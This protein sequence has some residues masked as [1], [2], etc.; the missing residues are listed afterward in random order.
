MLP[1]LPHCLAVPNQISDTF[2]FDAYLV[3]K[4]LIMGG[5]IVMKLRTRVLSSRL[6]LYLKNGFLSR[7]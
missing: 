3:E 4:N 1:L 7:S 5:M 2:T 6:S